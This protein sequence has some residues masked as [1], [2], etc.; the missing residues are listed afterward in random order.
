MQHSASS[1]NIVA[2]LFAHRLRHWLFIITEDKDGRIDMLIFLGPSTFSSVIMISFH[3][4]AMINREYG[5]KKEDQNLD[6]DG[7]LKKH[8]AIIVGTTLS[9]L[10][11]GFLWICRLWEILGDVNEPPENAF[12]V[13]AVV[14]VIISFSLWS[15]GDCHK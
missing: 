9:C 15:A 10:S 2:V 11:T 7:M 14:L 3:L 6:F 12:I 5:N 1:F 4:Y 8:W 13:L